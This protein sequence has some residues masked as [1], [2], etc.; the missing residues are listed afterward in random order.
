M[1]RI[2]GQP[3]IRTDNPA[4]F[5]IRYPAEHKITLPDTGYPATV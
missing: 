2:Y 4:F 3:D 5:Y 1:H